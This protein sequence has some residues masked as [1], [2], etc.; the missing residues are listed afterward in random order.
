[1]EAAMAG[2]YWAS[3][4]MTAQDLASSVSQG[5]SNTFIELIRCEYQKL[6]D[7]TAPTS[8]E[9]LWPLQRQ[10]IPLSAK[11][12][13][14]GE[15]GRMAKEHPAVEGQILAAVREFC[16]DVPSTNDAFAKAIAL[17]IR[18]HSMCA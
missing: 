13:S 12:S 14:I 7:Q 5:L 16:G 2:S 4:C 1:M 3:I 10:S 17:S 18:L 6:C 9:E 8:F 11:L 15:A